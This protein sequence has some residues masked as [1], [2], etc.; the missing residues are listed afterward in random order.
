MANED[1]THIN[2]TPPRARMPPQYLFCDKSFKSDMMERG[3]FV[4]EQGEKDG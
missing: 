3:I 4:L 1:E 2:T